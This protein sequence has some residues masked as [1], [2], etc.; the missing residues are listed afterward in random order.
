MSIIILVINYATGDREVALNCMR[1]YNISAISFLNNISDCI[2]FM[3]H[4]L[5]LH[6][7]ITKT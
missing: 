3:K 7:N 4:Y 1:Y 5:S 2:R 6:I